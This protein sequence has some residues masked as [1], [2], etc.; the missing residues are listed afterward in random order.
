MSRRHLA[1]RASI[2]R[3]I[4]SGRVIE[5]IRVLIIILA[6]VL[7]QG[8]AST[9]QLSPEPGEGQQ[10]IYQDGI[11]TVISRQSSVVQIRAASD[12][13]RSDQ[14]PQLMVAVYN[15]TD[16]PFDFSVADI[17]VFVDGK[18]IKVY[19]YDELAAEI[20]RA[21]GTADLAA[22]LLDGAQVSAAAAAGNGYY[23][24]GSSQAQFDREM[25]A[26]DIRTARKLSNLRATAVRRNTVFPH[27]WY[28]GTITLAAIPDSQPHKLKVVV[29]AGDDMHVFRLDDRCLDR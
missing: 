28:D 7:L 29:F 15:G 25:R 3:P 24:D 9:M 27:T 22:L 18:R 13:Y 2:I 19:K 14:R 4:I 6:G 23:D 17:A 8:C 26:A 1:A 21:Q 12:T 20:Q 5:V 16:A 11:G 10:K